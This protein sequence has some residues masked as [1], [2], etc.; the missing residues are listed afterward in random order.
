M[1]AS[2]A[3]LGIFRCKLGFCSRGWGRVWNYEGILPLKVDFNFF[4]QAYVS[5]IL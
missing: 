1:I 3:M 2:G 5:Y 4:L